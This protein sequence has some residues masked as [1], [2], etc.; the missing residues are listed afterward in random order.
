MPLLTKTKDQ[1]LSDIVSSW[2]S[3]LLLSPNL[4]PGDPL[5]AVF[6]AHVLGGLLFVQSQAVA[7]DKLTRAQTSV[8]ADLDSWMAQFGFTRL[9]PTK[10]SGTVTFS[11]RNVS[12]T[13]IELKAGTIIQTSD[14]KIKYQVIGD[15]NKPTWSPAL[16]AYVLNAGQLQLQAEVE[17][18]SA[19]SASNVQVG[20]LSQILSANT[21]LNFVTNTANISNGRD[22]ETDA[23]FFDRWILEFNAVN[24]RTTPAGVLS[25]ILNTPGVAEAKLVENE[26]VDGNPRPG[27]GYAVIDDG[28]GDPNPTLLT[29][30][31]N[32]VNA[33]SR[34][35]TV[36][37]LAVGPVLE[38]VDI[39]LA[40]KLDPN[41]RDSA[42]ILIPAATI[43]YNVAIAIINYVNSL[44]IGETLYLLNLSYVARSVPG[45]LAVQPGSVTIDGETEDYTV[46][47]KTVIRTNNTKTVISE[48]A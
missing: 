33:Q 15:T 44:P 17:A 22:A 2:A 43:L 31:T 34:G 10:A 48:W 27:Y 13:N 6:E 39:T 4:Q 16:N 47:N 8:G 7:I 5:L 18:V 41:A 28:S 21:G 12:Q 37:F 45:V 1:F 25:T 26:D 42:G 20:A 40:A 14:A 46:T 30:V 23:K 29:E 32:N 3:L 19:G 11:L 24:K 35:W 36:Q 9:P 38:E